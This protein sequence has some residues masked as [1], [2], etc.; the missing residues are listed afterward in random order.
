MKKVRYY[1]G[2]LKLLLI[3]EDTL[4]FIM[5]NFFYLEEM[6]LLNKDIDLEWKIIRFK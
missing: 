6:K 4:N 1:E 5:K 2:L 3:S